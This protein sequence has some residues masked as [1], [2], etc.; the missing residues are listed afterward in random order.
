MKEEHQLR[1]EGE[2]RG[3]CLASRSSSFILGPTERVG[4]GCRAG[5]EMET[6]LKREISRYCQ[7]SKVYDTRVKCI[8]L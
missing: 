8:L 6:L 7:E 3:E 1:S 2:D 5:L 4:V